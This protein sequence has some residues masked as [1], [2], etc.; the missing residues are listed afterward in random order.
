[1]NYLALL[2]QFVTLMSSA[3]LLSL[4]WLLLGITLSSTF[5]I[6]TDEQK[7]VANFPRNRLLGSLVGSALGFL[8]PVGAFGSVPIAR[9]LLLQGAPIPLAV[10]FLIAA[11]TLNILALADSL[12]AFYHQPRLIFLTIFLTWLLAIVLGLTF[13]TYRVSRQVEGD[14]AVNPLDNIPLL[15]SGALI[16]L[17]SSQ[18]SLPRS[19]G[20]IFGGGI[21]SNLDLALSQK[22]QLLG[23]NIIEEVQEFGGVLVLG[24][25]IAA[26]IVLFLPQLSLLQWAGQHLIAQTLVM[27]GL[28]FL[29]P[30]GSFNHQALVTPL[31]DQV[32]LGSSLG[33]L[34]LSALFNLQNL[35]LWLVTFRWRPLLYLSVLLL[36]FTFLFAMIANFYLT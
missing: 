27:M 33:F 13:S 7:W 35:A 25:A 4:P 20:I 6:W 24:T 15:R 1:M 3:L 29:L 2:R 23:R 26:G 21:Q 11:P 36:L 9:R 5:L 22:L 16:A 17:K 18:A 8:L 34:L 28:G 10:S 14:K 19:G 12:F 31:Q 30:L 32:W